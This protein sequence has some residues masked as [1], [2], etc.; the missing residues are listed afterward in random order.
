MLKGSL[1]SPVPS[2]TYPQVSKM[3][4]G[5]QLFSCLHIF[6][7]FMSPTERAQVILHSLWVCLC[8][9]H[10]TISDGLS[11]LFLP[12]IPTIL[13]HTP[14]HMRKHFMPH[15]VNPRILG[16]YCGGLQVCLVHMFPL[17]RDRSLP[18][19]PPSFLAALTP[20]SFKT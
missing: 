2:S 4:V 18:F 20:F 10:P 14:P 6:G 8:F 13:M 5:S 1:T 16:T 17:S 3:P 12:N 9:Y 15:N 11:A 7:R 19:L